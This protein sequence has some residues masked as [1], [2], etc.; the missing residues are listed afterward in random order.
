MKVYN[1]QELDRMGRSQLINIIKE[2]QLELEECHE[3]MSK[4]LEELNKDQDYTVVDS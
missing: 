2:L 4:A 3:L 1:Q